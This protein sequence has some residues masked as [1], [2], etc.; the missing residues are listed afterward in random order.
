M[1]GRYL[2]DTFADY[3]SPQDE[4]DARIVSPRLYALFRRVDEAWAR[5]RRRVEQKLEEQRLQEQRESSSR[6]QFCTHAASRRC[7][8]QSSA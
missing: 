1:M 2:K 7:L 6:P 3:W 8:F 4:H 5:N